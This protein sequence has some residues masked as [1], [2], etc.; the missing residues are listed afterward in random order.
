MDWFTCRGGPVQ[1]QDTEE[2]KQK[3]FQRAGVSKHGTTPS[4]GMAVKL[5]FIKS[6]LCKLPNVRGINS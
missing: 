5:Y 2:Q 3:G 6:Y 4:Y 1:L